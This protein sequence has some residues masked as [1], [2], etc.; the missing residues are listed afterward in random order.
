MTDFHNHRDVVG[1][2]SHQCEQCGTS[3]PVGEKHLSV[4]GSYYG[5]FYDYRVHY[6]CQTAARTYA[7]IHGLSGEEWPWFQHN[8]NESGDWQWM[9][10]NHPLVAKRLGWD[11]L[12]KEWCT[13]DSEPASDPRPAAELSPPG[14]K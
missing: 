4:A 3:I 9:V 12:W 13:D 10:E 6:E 5:D 8:E 14:D 1:R 11:G 7:H 2:K